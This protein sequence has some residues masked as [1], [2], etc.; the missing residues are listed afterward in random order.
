[1]RLKD[2]QVS[3]GSKWNWAAEATTAFASRQCAGHLLIQCWQAFTS[4]AFRCI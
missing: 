3:K 4:D 2:D 1:M